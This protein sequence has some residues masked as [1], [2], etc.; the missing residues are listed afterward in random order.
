MNNKLMYIILMYI[1]LSFTIFC[2]EF[3]FTANKDKTWTDSWEDTYTIRKG[4]KLKLGD[5]GIGFRYGNNPSNIDIALYTDFYEGVV[6]VDVQDITFDENTKAVSNHIKNYYWVPFYYYD[7]VHSETDRFSILYKNEPFWIN[8]QSQTEGQDI[9]D[10]QE[11]FYLGYYG[12][13][14]FYFFARSSQFGIGEAAFLV[15]TEEASDD[16]IKYKVYKMYSNSSYYTEPTANPQ[17]KF[18]PVYEKDT[19]F[20]IYLTVDGDY[21]YMYIDDISEENLFQTLIRTTSEACTQIENWIRG[22]SDNLSK[23]SWPR[24]ADGSCEYENAAQALQ[25]IAAGGIYRVAENLRLRETENTSSAV[26]TTMQAG[27][28]VKVLAAGKEETIDGISSNWVQVE[29][30]QEARDKDG[31][32]I[33]AGTTGWCFGGY[34]Q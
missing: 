4:E 33:P 25:Q 7:Q 19:P 30:Q 5:H 17:Q 29:V 16:Y 12:F 27:T 1:T 15:S 8:W 34:L 21:M 28:R 3:T 20:Y 6:F 2:E 23:V 18:I 24:H 13:S 9:G 14:D 31:N 22:E 11:D 32:T 10:W 26:I